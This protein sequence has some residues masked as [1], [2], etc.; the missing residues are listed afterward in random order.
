MPLRLT[1]FLA[2]LGLLTLAER[3]WPH[4]AAP[5]RRRQRWPANLGMGAIDVV[6]GFEVQRNGK[7]G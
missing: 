1:I 3:A 5:L 4:H 6:L 2:L 7:R